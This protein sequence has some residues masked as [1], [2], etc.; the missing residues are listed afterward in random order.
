MI[1]ASINVRFDG[2]F[3]LTPFNADLAAAEACFP[4]LPLAAAPVNTYASAIALDEL[5]ISA[6]AGT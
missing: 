5:A 1:L 6:A 3:L 2:N 4:A